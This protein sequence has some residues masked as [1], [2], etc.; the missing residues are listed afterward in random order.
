MYHK[1]TGVYP[2]TRWDI[3]Y[4]ILVYLFVWVIPVQ[5]CTC[6]GVN[7]AEEWEVDHLGHT[8]TDDATVHHHHHH[9]HHH[10]HHL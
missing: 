5:L 1:A 7:H 8:Q 4:K 9:H 3:G 2:T 6:E 10:Y